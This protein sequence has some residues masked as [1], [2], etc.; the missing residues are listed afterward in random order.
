MDREPDDL[1]RAVAKLYYI[2]EL[3]E[4]EVAGVV[5]VSR[6]RVSR[7]LTRARER[8]VVRISVDEYE[9]RNRALEDRLKQRY[10]LNQAVVVKTTVGQAIEHVRRSIGYFAAP[11]ASQWIR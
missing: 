2:D 6:S 8:G 5:G 10:R 11:V 9:P 3:P 4:R 1:L 7:L